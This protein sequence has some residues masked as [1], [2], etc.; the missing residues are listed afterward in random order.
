[1]EIKKNGLNLHQI[2]SKSTPVP[3]G[4]IGNLEEFIS[5]QISG[6]SS[7][8]AY[9][10]YKVQIGKFKDKKF[11]FYKDGKFETKYIQRLRVFN[12]TQELLIWRSSDGL[13][14]RLRTDDG[15]GNDTYIVDA[16]QVLFGTEAESLDGAHTKISEKR[17]TELILPFSGETLKQVQGDKEDKKN[18]MCIKTRNYVIPNDVHQ[19]TYEDC[20]FVCF[21][22]QEG[23]H[24]KKLE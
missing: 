12:E 8:V 4:N 11:Q 23:D 13:R 17:G 24:E 22:Y 9:L 6:N 18:R 1:M 7:V 19:A 15:A 10:D 2:K 14:G 21:V 3:C 16:L 5:Q 20:R